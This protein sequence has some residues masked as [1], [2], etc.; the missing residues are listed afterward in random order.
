MSRAPDSG[1]GE[2]APGF[3]TDSATDLAT[4]RA[5]NLAIIPARGGSKRIPRKNIKPF[6]GQPMLSYAIAAARASGLFSHI[7]VS[8]DDA[9]IADVARAYGAD[10]PFVR[11][12]ELANDHAGVIPVVGHAIGAC[13]DLGWQFERVCCIFACVP[14]MLPQDLQQSCAALQAAQADFAF[15]VAEFPSSIWRALR[16]LPDGTV[17]AFHPEHTATRSQDLE[18]AFYD[19]GQFYWGSEAAWLSGRSPHHGGLAHVIEPWRAVDI[20]TPDDWLRAEQIYAARA[21]GAGAIC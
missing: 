1:T 8:T 19:V 20:D 18:P 11:P 6:A 16:R 13:R 2:V 7:V 9:E 17:N 5:T 21:A 14:L 12:P 15:A 3:T 10:V 4:H